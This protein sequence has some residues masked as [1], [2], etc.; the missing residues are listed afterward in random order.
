MLGARQR[1]CA[2][3]TLGVTGTRAPLS[4]TLD[5]VRSIFPSTISTYNTHALQN[6]IASRPH[7][8]LLNPRW[9]LRRPVLLPRSCSSWT[10]CYWAADTHANVNGNAIDED[11]LKT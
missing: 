6:G 9:S 4:M 2:H 11:Q 1:Q 5:T 8:R 10:T 7:L 3:G